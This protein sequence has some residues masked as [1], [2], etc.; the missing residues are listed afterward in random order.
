[1]PC[2]ATRRDIIAYGSGSAYTCGQKSELG[3]RAGVG[4]WMALS[5][6]E[7]KRSNE[8]DIPCEGSVL[9][10]VFSPAEVVEM[11][12]S[13]AKVGHRDVVGDL[14]CGDG[15]AL[16]TAALEFNAH[17]YGIDVRPCCIQACE[18]TA[19]IHRVR[20]HTSPALNTFSPLS[21]GHLGSHHLDS[22]PSIPL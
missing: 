7:L 12:L 19:R 9:P 10:V 6:A 8:L 13:L 2:S 3:V 20:S 15:R 14:G 1:V 11:A 5:S 16:L 17:G 4:G 18:K 22:Y 21:Q